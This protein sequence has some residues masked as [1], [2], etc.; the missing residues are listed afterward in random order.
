MPTTTAPTAHRIAEALDQARHA[1]HHPDCTCGLYRG[2]LNA[3]YCTDSECRWSAMVDRIL[4]TIQ[5]EQQ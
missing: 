5:R 3:P 4:T 1:R 2:P